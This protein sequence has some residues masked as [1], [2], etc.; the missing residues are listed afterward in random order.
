MTRQDAR[1]TILAAVNKW[2][3]DRSIHTLPQYCL[4]EIEKAVCCARSRN[5][6]DGDTLVAAGFNTK[7]GR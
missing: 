6:V 2:R 3:N 7:K 1:K 4:S 5:L